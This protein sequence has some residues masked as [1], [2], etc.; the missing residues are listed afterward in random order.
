[1]KTEELTQLV[2]DAL[3]E[4]KA[5]NLHV[6]DVRGK[7]S[8]T[9]VMVIATGTSS[10]HV[11]SLAENVALTAKKQGMPALGE[12]G[13]DTGEWALIDLGDV[14]VHVMQEEIRDFYQLEKLWETDEKPGDAA[15]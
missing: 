9:D 7:T 12:E 6:I 5:V 3:E 10:R 2:V 4:L 14:V 15:E 11:R 13:I 8:I 1:M